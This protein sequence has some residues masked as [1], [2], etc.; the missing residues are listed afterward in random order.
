MPDQHSSTIKHASEILTQLIVDNDQICA[1]CER[2]AKEVSGTKYW[3]PQD[4]EQ[5]EGTA[6]YDLYWSV[7]GSVQA[8]VAS[9]A[10][11]TLVGAF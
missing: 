7:Y 3:T 4:F 10:S 9:I 8:K 5:N 2:I 11:I 1:V 6:Q